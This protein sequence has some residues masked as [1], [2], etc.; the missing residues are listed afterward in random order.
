MLWT[1]MEISIDCPHC[2]SPVHV[3]G[4]YRKLTCSRCHS[5][6]DFPGEVW[7]DTLEE[8]RQDVSGYEKGEGTGSNIFGHFNMRMTYGRLDPYCLKCKRDFDLEADYPQL[9]MIRCPDCGTE[10]PVAPAAVWFREAVPGAAL[11]VGAWPEGENAPDEERD[12]PKPV[13]Y[14][15][16]QCGGSLMIDGEKRIVECSYCSTSIYLPDDLWLT[17]HPAKT[18]T[19]WFIGFK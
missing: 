8:V 7:K 17:L 13:A 12:K 6:I 11:I 4:P 2:D 18:K 9:T 14:S 3:D 16:P 10:S 5:E 1:M 19:R 15:C